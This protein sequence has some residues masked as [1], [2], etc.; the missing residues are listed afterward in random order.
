LLDAVADVIDHSATVV[1][2]LRA[3]EIKIAGLESEV[4]ELKA[5]N[6]KLREQLEAARAAGSQIRDRAGTYLD[7][8][9]I[10]DC[11]RR[12]PKAVTS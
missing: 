5:E 12:V 9:P 3:A 2:K 8:G 1:E 11:L 10:P 4:E 7:P 6:A